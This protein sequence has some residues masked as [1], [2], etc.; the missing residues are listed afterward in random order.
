MPTS[1]FV[2]SALRMSLLSIVKV[3]K[4]FSTT[5]FIFRLVQPFLGITEKQ[6]LTISSFFALSARLVL[7]R[8]LP[9][10]FRPSKAFSTHSISFRRNSVRI[11]SISRRGSTSPSTCMTSAS[12]KARTT[13]KMP[14][15]E[16]T[17]ERKEFPS[18]TF[19]DAP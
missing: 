16:R 18:P 1:L 5:A 6:E 15:T 8:A 19:A 13:W 3:F 10:L 17:Y 9:D 7:P 14:S 4:T 2:Q 12:S 11:I